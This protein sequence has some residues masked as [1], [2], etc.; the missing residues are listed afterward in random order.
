[1]KLI[2][3]FFLLSSITIISAQTKGETYSY[4]NNKLSTYSLKDIDI[5][6]GYL[7][8]EIEPALGMYFINIIEADSFGMTTVWAFEPK[9]FGSIN[10]VKN[11]NT[12]WLKINS[13]SDKINSYTIYNGSESEI[14]KKSEIT[15]ILNSDTSEEQLKRMEKAFK[16]LLKQYNVDTKDPFAD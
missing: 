16:H 14:S 5:K 13:K 15:I 6:Y 11:P 9:D 3:T 2:I 7:I 10:I 1:M 8:Q 4:L 12:I